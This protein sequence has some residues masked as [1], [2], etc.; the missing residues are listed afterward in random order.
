M[1]VIASTDDFDTNNQ[2]LSN[3]VYKLIAYPGKTK[4]NYR[5]TKMLKVSMTDSQQWKDLVLDNANFTKVLKETI[6]AQLGT[7]CKEVLSKD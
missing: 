4:C 2:C 1:I 6:V 3:K 7:V 5:L